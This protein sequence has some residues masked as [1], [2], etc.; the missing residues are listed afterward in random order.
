MSKEIKTE[1]RGKWPSGAK[2][3][4][5]RAG[6]KPTRPVPLELLSISSD[7]AP[8]TT[9]ASTGGHYTPIFSDL[10][11]GQRLICPPDRAV[12]VAASLKQWLRKRGINARVQSCSDYP[13]DHMGGVWWWHKQDE[14]AA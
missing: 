1:I 5:S 8:T 7:P 4:I 10:K 6:M 3:R 9:G 14:K 12:A 13:K 2:S 11:P